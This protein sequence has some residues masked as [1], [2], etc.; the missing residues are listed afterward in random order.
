MKK[1]WL[2]IVVLVFLFFGCF[3]SPS[4][5]DSDPKGKISFNETTSGNKV[6]EI[7]YRFI[8]GGWD[9]NNS[10]VRGAVFTLSENTLAISGGGVLI[11]YYGV[12]SEGEGIWEGALWSYL[13]SGSIKIGF[14]YKAQN[15]QIIAV[16]GKT[17]AEKF[18]SV[19][20]LKTDDMQDI[21]NGVGWSKI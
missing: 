5:L 15:D 18:E 1:N 9:V 10:E 21:N 16:I 3:S 7:K 6:V 8:D 4:V 13:F 20:G 2:G 14:I 12:Y 17:H 19:P 11:S